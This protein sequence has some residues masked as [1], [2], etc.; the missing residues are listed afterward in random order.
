M[1]SKQKLPQPSVRMICLFTTS[2]SYR[3]FFSK[4]LYFGYQNIKNQKKGGEE[5]E[6]LWKNENT[7]KSLRNFEFGIEVLRNHILHI[8][9]K[10]IEIFLYV[11]TNSV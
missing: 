9:E 2:F 7:I 3:F 6:D 10:S 1:K 5:E 11:R 4:L 8:L